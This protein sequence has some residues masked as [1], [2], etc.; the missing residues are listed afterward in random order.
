MAST[1]YVA[2]VVMGSARKDITAGSIH[3]LYCTCCS[4]KPLLCMLSV[5]GSHVSYARH[6][7]NLLPIPLARGARFIMGM[8]LGNVQAL[9][10][11]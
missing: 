5:R 8:V 2:Q 4:R 9:A 11:V 6:L 1:G 7:I 10:E 3:R